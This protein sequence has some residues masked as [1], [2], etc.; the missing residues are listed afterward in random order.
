MARPFKQGLSYFPLDVGYHRDS[1]IRTIK[2][3]TGIVGVHVYLCILMLV[4]EQGYFLEMSKEE[5]AEVIFDDLRGP[6]LRSID[7]IT[8]VISLLAKSGLIE[9]SLLSSKVITSRSIQKQWL[10]SVSRRKSVDKSR[11][12]LLSDNDEVGIKKFTND[13]VVSTHPEIVNV[14]N[15]KD[16]VDNNLVNVNQS[17]QKEKEKEID[18]DKEINKDK[19]VFA[20]PKLHFITQALI[21]NRYIKEDD[22]SIGR[23]NLLANDLV[24][25]YGF[26][27]VLSVTDYI[28]KV[29]KRDH[30]KIEE[31]FEYYKASAERNIILFIKQNNGGV[32]RLGK[33]I[34]K[35]IKTMD[36][37]N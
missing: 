3:K 2:L 11:Y 32:F 8:E 15:N 35:F 31:P 14:N 34:D 21:N 23:F 16:N 20:T 7:R 4:Y 6:G 5:L 18:N 25:K 29:S 10:T 9:E 17:T 12:W 33:E 22:L 37:Q 1:R 26:D 27:L 13:Y 28:V 30:I 19:G 24:E 36:K